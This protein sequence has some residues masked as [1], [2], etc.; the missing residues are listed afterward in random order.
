M[1]LR[2][3]LLFTVIPLVELYLLIRLGTYL[4]VLDTLAVVIATGIVGGLLARS[5]GLAVLNRIRMELEEGRIPAESLFDGVMILVAGILLITPGLRTDG[6]GLCLLI[7]WTRQVLKL[8]L[9]QKVQ[10]KVSKGEIGGQES[11]RTIEP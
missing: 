8:W 9:Q 1:L 3:F 10:G 11:N 6:L 7:P 2:L 4:G 5:Q